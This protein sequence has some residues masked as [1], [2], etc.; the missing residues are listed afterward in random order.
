MTYPYHRWGIIAARARVCVG[1]EFW[2]AM[3]KDGWSSVVTTTIRRHAV[4]A[5][6]REQKVSSKRTLTRG[7]IISRGYR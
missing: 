6:E 5:E 1:G 2:G 3:G 7:S 4:V